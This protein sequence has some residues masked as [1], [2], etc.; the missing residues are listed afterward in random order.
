MPRYNTKRTNTLA[1]EYQDYVNFRGK[2]EDKLQNYDLSLPVYKAGVRMGIPFFYGI[3]N[4]GFHLTYDAQN[5]KAFFMWQK[6]K[7]VCKIIQ[8]EDIEEIYT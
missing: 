6:V 5:P 2:V 4:D 7:N 3:Y 1:Q 8:E